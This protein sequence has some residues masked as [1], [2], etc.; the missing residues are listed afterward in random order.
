MGITFLADEK[1]QWYDNISDEQKQSMVRLVIDE[2]ISKEGFAAEFSI[3][4]RALAIR[5]YH[6]IRKM[7]GSGFSDDQRK[8][9]IRNIK[10]LDKD[11]EIAFTDSNQQWYDSVP[12][13]VR[14]SMV[15]YVVEQNISYEK[16]ATMF[17]FPTTSIAHRFHTFITENFANSNIGSSANP[18][19]FPPNVKESIVNQVLSK[20]ATAEHL[21]QSHSI[22]V[23][24][25]NEWVKEKRR[26]MFHL[27]QTKNEKTKTKGNAFQKCPIC[28]L[29]KN[30]SGRRFRVKFHL[31]VEHSNHPE[32]SKYVSEEELKKFNNFKSAEGWK[33]L[34]ERRKRK[35]EENILLQENE[36]RPVLDT[37]AIAK[38]FSSLRCG[39]CQKVF[40]SKSKR[41]KH[42][43][44]AH[45][46]EWRMVLESR[47]L[48]RDNPKKIIKVHDNTSNSFEEELK[49]FTELL[50]AKSQENVNIRDDPNLNVQ[51]TTIE[52]FEPKIEKEGI[53]EEV[54]EVSDTEED[55]LVAPKDMDVKAIEY[56]EP[57]LEKEGI[58]EEV[59][60]ISDTEEDTLVAPKDMDV[61]ANNEALD[62][63]QNGEVDLQPENPPYIKFQFGSTPLEIAREP[64]LEKEGIKKEV[65]EMSDT[66]EDTLVAPKDT[67]VK[68]NTNNEVL[69]AIQN[70]KVD[71]QPENPPNIKFQY[72][73]TP[74]EIACVSGNCDLVETFLGKGAAFGDK[75]NYV[76]DVLMKKQMFDVL[77][78]LKNHNNNGAKD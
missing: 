12:E 27:R 1:N 5:I 68:A 73:W 39:L 20:E 24:V 41:T 50:K 14:F 77:D 23:H 56:F 76:I 55:T 6:W 18:S 59:M 17:F 33:M 63:I 60:E 29:D 47:S 44:S 67:D 28:G 26:E 52:Y 69:D 48:S 43:R 54:I 57:K 35:N 25:I 19:S 38:F 53:K 9:T 8:G 64:K 62:A 49:K 36:S 74:L 11:L 61:K 10:F 31:K 32:I 65:I 45:S 16:L 2:N 3:P 71:L 75:E 13:E 46:Y 66:E 30:P 15:G 4:T 37:N 34:H 70:G 22:P 42:Y 58:K 72:G 7:F 21:A 40:P 78:L 51:R